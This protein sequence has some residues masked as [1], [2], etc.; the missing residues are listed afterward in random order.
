[1]EV[2]IEGY[3]RIIH[4]IPFFFF[5]IYS[6]SGAKGTNIPLSFFNAKCNY[7]CMYICSSFFFS[8]V[9]F[10]IQKKKKTN[11][12]DDHMAIFF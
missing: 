1:M 8:S 2:L 6:F 7:V 12:V 11:Y 4:S 10:K 5:L 3:T 9:F